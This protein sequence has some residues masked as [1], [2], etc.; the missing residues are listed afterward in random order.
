[1][2]DRASNGKHSYCNA[3]KLDLIKQLK[4]VVLWINRRKSYSNLRMIPIIKIA[5]VAENYLTI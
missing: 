1:M 3:L 4:E 2:F 5:L